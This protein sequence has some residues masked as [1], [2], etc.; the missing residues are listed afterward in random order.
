MLRLNKVPRIK[1]KKNESE[2]DTDDGEDGDQVSMMKMKDIAMPKT[3]RKDGVS[4]CDDDEAGRCQRTCQRFPRKRVAEGRRQSGGSSALV[5]SRQL[6]IGLKRPS[7][8]LS[9]SSASSSSSSSSVRSHH[10]LYRIC[11]LYLHLLLL[12]DSLQSLAFGESHFQVIS[13]V[14]TLLLFYSSVLFF[15]LSLFIIISCISL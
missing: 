1:L 15:P 7:S 2:E 3:R 8:S 9:S 12:L 6:K 14:C 4:D 13:F 5:T 11:L 10:W